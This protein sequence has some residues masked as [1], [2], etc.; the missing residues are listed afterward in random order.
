MIRK[1]LIVGV[2]GLSTVISSCGDGMP[3]DMCDCIGISIEISEKVNEAGF[4][5]EKISEIEKE[6]EQHL[7]KCESIQEE[8]Q[9]S[10]DG[11]SS[12]E[13]EE[14]EKLLKENC[15]PLNN[16][17][18]KQGMNEPLSSFSSSNIKDMCDC[19]GVQ[20]EIMKE[21]ADLEFDDPKAKEVEAQYEAEMEACDELSK[22]Y[23]EKFAEMS[24]E[25]IEAEQ[26]DILDNC[27]A[28]DELQELMD[29]QMK[30][31]EEQMQDMDMG[32]M[33]DMDIDMEEL[34]EEM[35]QEEMEDVQ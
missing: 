26:Q 20:V 24:Q 34:N 3:K 15:E 21:T 5:N 9:N 8:Y 17:L 16:M 4:E 13:K 19:I 35:E 2:V 27:A 25:E 18:E 23:E 31:F 12:E 7:E 30:K 28:Y 32:D 33:E 11:L 1:A 6:Y 22:E 29:A 10:L 14:K